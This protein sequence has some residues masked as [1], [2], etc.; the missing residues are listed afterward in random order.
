MNHRVI[1]VE[2]GPVED[3][4]DISVP[5]TQNFAL[6]AGVFVHNSKDVSDALAGAVYGLTPARKRVNKEKLH[7]RMPVGGPRQVPAM[8]VGGK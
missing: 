2:P 3:V 8:T 4:Y 1:T 7:S 5:G 6:A